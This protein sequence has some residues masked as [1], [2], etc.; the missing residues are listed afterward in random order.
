MLHR[1]IRSGQGQLDEAAHFF[2]FFFLNPLERIEVFYFAGNSAV[3]R[4][5]IE[6]GDWPNAADT[7][8]EVF[9]TLVRAN[10]Q[11]ADQPNSRHHYPASHS[12]PA[13]VRVSGFVPANP[14][15]NK[16]SGFVPANPE[17]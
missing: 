8:Y 4:G 17:L 14:E 7:G 6:L 2:Q 15:V 13:P 10:T 16:S 11:R 3:E 12:S 9:P 5:S 1:G